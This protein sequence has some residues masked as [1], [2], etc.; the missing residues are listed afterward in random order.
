MASD[1]FIKGIYIKLY[2]LFK[3]IIIIISYIIKFIINILKGVPKIISWIIGG[4]ILFYI[5]R[6]LL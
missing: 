4:I 5:I 2:E 3:L 6:F 1:N